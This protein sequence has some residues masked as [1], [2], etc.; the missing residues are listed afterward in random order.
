[1]TKIYGVTLKELQVVMWC[2][3]PEIQSIALHTGH[4]DWR[5]LDICIIL[6]HFH[7][8]FL[9]VK[10]FCTKHASGVLHQSEKL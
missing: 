10:I 8:V 5:N 6:N 1:M 2:N 3:N 7:K 4:E 9:I